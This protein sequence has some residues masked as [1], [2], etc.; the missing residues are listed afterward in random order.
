MADNFTVFKHQGSTLRDWPVEWDIN[1]AR[2]KIT[3]TAPFISTSLLILACQTI[4]KKHPEAENYAWILS[5]GETQFSIVFGNTFVNAGNEM[6][7]NLM[8]IVINKKL[9]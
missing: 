4:A 2:K 3:L 9:L 7:A 1:H 8:P 5:V 6:S